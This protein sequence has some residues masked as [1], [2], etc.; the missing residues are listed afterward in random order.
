MISSVTIKSSA[1]NDRNGRTFSSISSSL[2][3]WLA[4][5]VLFD[6]P[7]PLHPRPTLPSFLA[8]LSLCHKLEKTLRIQMLVSLFSHCTEFTSCEEGLLLFV[9]DLPKVLL[10]IPL[11]ILLERT[12][13][14]RVS[15]TTPCKKS[16]SHGEGRSCLVWCRFVSKILSR[17]CS[18][19]S[20]Y[21]DAN[22]LPTMSRSSGRVP[23]A[24]LVFWLRSYSILRLHATSQRSSYDRS[25][26]S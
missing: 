22:A 11:A 13:K 6:L 26:K 4:F 10:S 9:F 21:D 15:P 24:L 8:A 12:G 1:P 18:E 14:V 3:H 20:F 2:I 19:R 25:E 7:I 17:A 16:C 5:L 23:L